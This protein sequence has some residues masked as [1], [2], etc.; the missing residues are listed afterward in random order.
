MSI[1][2]CVVSIIYV[3][4]HVTHS[5]SNTGIIVRRGPGGKYRQG[6][7]E[8]EQEEWE[9]QEEEE[10]EGQLWQEKAWEGGRRKQDHLQPAQGGT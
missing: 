10:A 8:E 6:D 9:E 1:I 7:A 2:Q 3:G 5:Y 4:L